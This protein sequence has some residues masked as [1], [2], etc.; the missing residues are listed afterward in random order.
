MGSFVSKLFRERKDASND[1]RSPTLHISRTPINLLFKQSPAKQITKAQ[2]LTDIRT[3]LSGSFENVYP[4]TKHMEMLQTTT[5]PIDPRSPSTEIHRTPLIL[6]N[7]EE[8][9]SQ[10]E[11]EICDAQNASVSESFES[12]LSKL[13]FN[14]SFDDEDGETEEKG[15]LDTQM[16]GLLETNFDYDPSKEPAQIVEDTIDPRSPGIERT[17]FVFEDEPNTKDC[18]DSTPKSTL[19]LEDRS[20]NGTKVFQDEN[21]G[22]CHTPKQINQEGNR[23]PLSCLANRTTRNTFKD[24]PSNMFVLKNKNDTE[25]YPVSTYSGVKG[26]NVK[27]I[28]SKIPLPMK[29]LTNK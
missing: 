10:V 18:E 14:T 27:D 19:N 12:A 6:L 15:L 17:P 3:P 9:V 28:N 11:A 13:D 4:R 8:M 26:M 20:R 25:N 21:S 23:T 29:R 5:N 22:Q 24:S 16:E 1:P 2:D 7:N